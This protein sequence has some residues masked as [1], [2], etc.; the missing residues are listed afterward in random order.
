MMGPRA[1]NSRDR[2]W[3][4][5][6]SFDAIHKIAHNH[7]AWTV[8]PDVPISRRKKRHMLFNPQGKNVASSPE[9]ADLFD[10]IGAHDGAKIIFL[11]T[12]CPFPVYCS[13][14]DL[15]AQIWKE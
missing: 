7:D 10:V 8:C 2:K 14:A 11:F 5:A 9:L 13:A 15:V 1:A 6:P 4:N 3:R 12:G